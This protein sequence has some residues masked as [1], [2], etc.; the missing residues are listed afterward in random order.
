MS[1]L[2]LAEGGVVRH[3]PGIQGG[4]DLVPAIHG[5]TDL[6]AEVEITRTD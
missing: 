6:V 1:N 5:W 3:H 2:A 4:V